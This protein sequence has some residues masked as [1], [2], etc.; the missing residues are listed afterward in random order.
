M[1]TAFFGKSLADEG[2]H[3]LDPFTGTGTFITRTLE[4]LKRQMDD[5]QIT[6]DDILRKYMHELHANEIVLL[7]YYIAAI[8][9]EAVFDEVNGPDRGYQPFEGIVL[10]KGLS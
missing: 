2:V 10:L 8:N 6:Y 1:R 4:Y 9:I 5:G 7:S 3:I